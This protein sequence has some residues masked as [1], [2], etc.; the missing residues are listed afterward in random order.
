MH[1]L[2][3]RLEPF[4]AYIQRYP[5]LL[6]LISFVMGVGSFFLV[7]RQNRSAGLIATVLLVSWVWLMLENLITHKLAQRFNLAISPVLLRYITQLIH[8]ESY[9][10]VIPF[11]LVTTTWNSGQ[12]VFIGLLVLAALSSTIDPLY[13]R[14]LAKHK[15]LFMGFHTLALFSVLLTALPVI[16]QLTTT[17]TYAFATGCTVILALPTLLRLLAEDRTWLVFLRLLTLVLALSS[18][19][20]VMR[21]WVPPATLWLTDMHV[22]QNLDSTNK[23]PVNPVQHLTQS[24]LQNKGLY[25]YTAIRAPRGL[26]EQV[27]HV[28]ELNGNE[29]DR[30]ALKIRGGREQGY[31]TW[32]HKTV[33]PDNAVGQWQV[34]VMTSFVYIMRHADWLR[35]GEE[36]EWA[37]EG[38]KE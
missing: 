27:F 17:E 29:L 34:Q 12:P 14:W 21:F 8:Q 37:E 30:I 15:M 32:T 36:E 24:Q 31:R 4:I 7:N 11:F 25:A 3:T 10:F 23:A 18:F 9:F 16:L 26:A 33:F 5:R 2:Q 22:S 38:K 1:V 6:A 13:Y 20:W 28:W 35:Q 19:L